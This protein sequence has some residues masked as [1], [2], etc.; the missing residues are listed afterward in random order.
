MVGRESVQQRKHDGAEDQHQPVCRQSDLRMRQETRLSIKPLP[1]HQ[2]LPNKEPEV[3]VDRDLFS[4]QGLLLSRS[5]KLRSISERRGTRRSGA[6]KF[7]TSAWTAADR[8][9]FLVNV[10]HVMQLD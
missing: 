9:Q 6:F 5:A 8:D 7:K 3:C 2:T 4:F 1:N 10:L